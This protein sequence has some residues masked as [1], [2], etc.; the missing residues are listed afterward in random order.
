[1]AEAGESASGGQ[2]EPTAEELVEEFQ[3]LKASDLVLSTMYTLSQL[4]YGKLDPASGDLEQARVAIESL[5]VLIPVVRGVAADELVRDFEQVLANLQ[6]AYASAVAGRPEA[7]EPDA[8]KAPAAAE[9]AAESG[10]R[11]EPPA[12]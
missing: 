7:K 1:M 2:A 9:P 5:R 6:L 3:K 11:E 4:A 10:E 8:P 12:G